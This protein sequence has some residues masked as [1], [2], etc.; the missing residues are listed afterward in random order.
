MNI[1]CLTEAP[2]EIMLNMGYVGLTIG[3]VL[4]VILLVSYGRIFAKAGQ[5]GWKVLIPFYNG[6]IFYKII[7]RSAIWWVLL[8][9][10]LLLTIYSLL[11]QDT[12]TFLTVIYSILTVVLLIV[13]GVLLLWGQIKLAK[14]FGK[15]VWY[16]IG[17]FF[18]P[19][20]FV[21]IIAFGGATYS[22][23]VIKRK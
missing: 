7:W 17:L 22:S 12:A 11:L 3:L 20:I 18:L 15:C 23:P 1:F 4:V 2:K 13:M 16:G 8:G 6:H 19:V 5:S 9:A 21:P 14:S 10:G